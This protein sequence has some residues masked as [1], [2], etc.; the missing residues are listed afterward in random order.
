MELN[1]LSRDLLK[2]ETEMRT[3]T[4]RGDISTDI[5][6]RVEKEREI[7]ANCEIQISS[8]NSHLNQLLDELRS[9][10]LVEQRRYDMALENE[11]M[12]HHLKLDI[13]SIKYELEQVKIQKT[14][15]KNDNEHLYEEKMDFQRNNNELKETI[16]L[17]NNDNDKYRKDNFIEG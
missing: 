2:L 6:L 16:N 12:N 8:F 4:K 3:L 14:Q 15:I 5:R 9:M 17:I 10:E 7:V 1:D 11:K 13:D